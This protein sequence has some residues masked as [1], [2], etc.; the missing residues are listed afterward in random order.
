MAISINANWDK[1]FQEWA[2]K[3]IKPC[4]EVTLNRKIIYILPSANGLFVLV[5]AGL[6][7]IAAI[8]YAVSLAF[9]LAFMMVSIFI[10]GI[11]YTFNNL[12][13]LSLASLSPASVF[14]GEEIAY[15]VQISRAPG[16]RHEALEFNFPGENI[17]TA[18]LTDNDQ[19]E[20]R[21]FTEAKTR[22][23]FPAPLLRIT[24]FYPLG[25]ARAWSLVDLDQRCLVYPKPIPFVMDQFTHGGGGSDDSAIIKEG[26]EDFYGL[27]DYV[28]GDPLRQVAWKNVARGQGMQVKQFVDYVDKRI[29]LDWD[30]FY[31][32]NT[33]ERLSRLCYGVLMLA[34]G[35]QAFGMKLP[36]IEIAPDCGAAHK[37]K[38]LKTLAL[39][40]TEENE[41]A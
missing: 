16:R 28:P 7:F 27:R 8:N 21:V 5:A 37:Q 19:E 2:R 13:Q 41:G 36:G 3:R 20:I 6:I 15:R 26:S 32:F 11:F 4:D 40:G 31:G 30:M 38:L 1:R 29:W 18:D 12:N 17:T 24:T 10:L 23:Y 35:G 39:F 14:V 9:G 34:K 25:L 33:E 22:G